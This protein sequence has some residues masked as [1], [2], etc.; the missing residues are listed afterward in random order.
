ML[1]S[2]L[3]SCFLYSASTY[4]LYIQS[5]STFDATYWLTNVDFYKNYI[6]LFGF[7]SNYFLNLMKQK[8]Y[9]FFDLAEFNLFGASRFFI[10]RKKARK[11]GKYFGKFVMNFD[12]TYINKD[13]Q[14]R[15]KRSFRLKFLKKHLNNKLTNINL[16]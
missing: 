2:K 7:F 13:F 1:V 5:I 10:F 4:N 8:F 12:R 3:S 15:F 11:I 14:D 16:F 6:N 9:N